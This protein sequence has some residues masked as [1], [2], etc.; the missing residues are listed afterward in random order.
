M[1]DLLSRIK[2]VSREVG[3]EVIGVTSVEPMLRDLAALSGWC[4]SGYAADMS[5]MTRQPE[6]NASPGRL[7]HWARSIITLGVNYYTAAPEFRHENRYGRVARYAWGLDYHDVVKAK[8]GELADRIRSLMDDAG[9]QARGFVDAVPLLERAAAERAGLGFFGKNTNLLRPSQGSW[10]FLAELFVNIDL[11]ATGEPRQVSCGTC[12][13][14]M[15][16]CPTNAFAGPYLLDSRLCISYLTIENKGPIPRELREAIGEWLFGCDVC[17]EVCPF[18]RFAEDTNWRHLRAEHG[19]GQRIDLIELLGISTDARFREWCK[20]TPLTRPKR[21]GLLRNAAVA[22]ANIG[23]EAAIPVLSMLIVDD[24]EP[25][26]RGHALWALARLELKRA[27]KFADA[28]LRND[29]DSFV[30]EEAEAI[31]SGCFARQES[32]K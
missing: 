12:S 14:C 4:S 19:K 22:A 27:S 11:P 1:S 2:A 24:P 15:P 31:L 32:K 9:F 3:F 18:N 20:G 29:N 7:V 17:Q 28:A 30:R 26:I 6:L 8:L 25:L 23:C 10:F 5:Y 16:A 13:R 21:R